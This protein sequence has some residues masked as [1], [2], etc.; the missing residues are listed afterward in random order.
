MPPVVDKNAKAR[1][2]YL[3][4]TSAGDKS[5]LNYWFRGKHNFDLWINYY[6]DVE[7]RYENDC[8]FYTS[9][10]GG[11][12]PNL[13]YVYHCWAEL[14]SS[15]DSILVMDDDIIIRGEEI[16]RLFEIRSEYDLWLLQP[17]FDPR[18]K[19]S[20]RVTRNNPLTS[21]RYT[22]FVEV[23]CPLFRKDKLDEFMQIYDPSV[24]GWGVDLWFLDS[25][26]EAAK[27][28]AITDDITC[29]NPADSMKQ[30][31]REIDLLQTTS[32]RIQNWERVKEQYNIE[33]RAPAEMSRISRSLNLKQFLKAMKIVMVHLYCKLLKM[34]YGV[35]ND[36]NRK[37]SG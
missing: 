15:Y 5:N 22:N 20:H 4:F 1:S 12:F 23:T 11:K 19:I 10:K 9:K 35:G 26:G 34:L 32:K 31:Q 28:V 3:V 27:K 14:I 16:N 18:G 25:L 33:V 37:A 21:L 17:A 30:G 24:V 7:G 8:D 2:K 13:H 6:G 29:I 36:Y